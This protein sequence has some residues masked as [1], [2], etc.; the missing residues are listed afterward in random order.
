M[1]TPI[2]PRGSRPR[3]WCRLTSGLEELEKW[4]CNATQGEK[5]VVYDALFAVA[6][7]SVF[8]T[9]QVVDDI[10][11][12]TQFFVLTR[13]YLAVKIRIHGFDDFGIVYIGPSSDAPGI[14][15]DPTC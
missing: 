4:S 14:D 13:G 10:N 15:P 9:H 6:D 12:P 2:Q 1:T 8:S 7:R 5:N 3:L 11:R